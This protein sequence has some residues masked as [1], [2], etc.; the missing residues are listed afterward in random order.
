[1]EGWCGLV[2]F[3]VA[4]LIAQV[5]KVVARLMS[6]V[7]SGEKMSF[8][9]MIDCFT[10]SGGMPSGHTA[11]FTAAAVFL[12]LAFGWGSGLFV[13]AVCMW[14]VI[15]YDATH[16]R[17]AVGEQG[18]ALNRLLKEAGEPE[19]PVVEGHTVVQ[20]VVGATIGLI[21]GWGVFVLARLMLK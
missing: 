19:L 16:V 1:M 15:V 9:V 8:G 17:Y 6:G 18:R 5:S 4:W 13:L 14:M 10:R 12:G 7:K 20:V 2:A 21:V 11:S 3:T